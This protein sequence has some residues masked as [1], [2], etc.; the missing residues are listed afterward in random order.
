MEML[1]TKRFLPRYADWL[2]VLFT[3]LFLP[4]RFY[5]AWLEGGHAA[6]ARARRA[7]YIW[8]CSFWDED[9]TKEN[10][11]RSHWTISLNPFLIDM[12]LAAFFTSVV[13]FAIRRGPDSVDWLFTLG[14]FALEY[15][16]RCLFHIFVQVQWFCS[17]LELHDQRTLRLF[18]SLMSI[19]LFR[20]W[21]VI[22][23]LFSALVIAGASIGAFYMLRVFYLGQ[24]D[25]ELPP[26]FKYLLGV[27]ALVSFPAGVLGSCFLL[28]LSGCQI[29]IIVSDTF[30]RVKRTYSR[31]SWA[32]R[33]TTTTPDRE[34]QLV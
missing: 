31:D 24:D 19:H 8:A 6:T 29:W 12:G 27:I 34:I 10:L 3:S 17:V 4:T 13:F 25:G 9:K 14:P 30:W 18:S 1:Q 2:C 11:S 20:A 22:F 5:I 26:W 15:Y 32:H 21:I 16:L 7:R 33:H 28:C 23:C